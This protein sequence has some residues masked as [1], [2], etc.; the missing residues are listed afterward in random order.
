M[1]QALIVIA[2]FAVAALFLG[3]RFLGVFSGKSRPGCEKCAA[4][5]LSK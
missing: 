5:E 2:L 1:V 3:K 4:K